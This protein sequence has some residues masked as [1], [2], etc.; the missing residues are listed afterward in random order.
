MTEITSRV[1]RLVVILLQQ[2]VPN[3]D[4]RDKRHK[5]VVEGCV[6][7][8]EQ[9]VADIVD[10]VERG[11]VP[12]PHIDVLWPKMHLILHQDHFF[13]QLV[14]FDLKLCVVRSGGLPGED[15]QISLIRKQGV[16]AIIVA[17]RVE[18]V[19]EVCDDEHD[20]EVGDDVKLG[21]PV[22]QNDVNVANLNDHTDGQLKEAGKEGE[23]E[24]A[25][26]PRVI[27]RVLHHVQALLE[28]LLNKN[29]HHNLRDKASHAVLRRKLLLVD[30]L[31]VDVGA[32]D[33]VEVE[34]E[35]EGPDDEHV[36]EV[37]LRYHIVLHPD[38]LHS[39][40]VQLPYVHCTTRGTILHTELLSHHHHLL[41]M[42]CVFLLFIK[43]FSD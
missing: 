42:V 18:V 4:G 30:A 36:F 23:A 41:H 5:V 14:F 19:V 3:E 31:K 12:E 33:D 15:A 38:M 32:E 8:L 40:L 43:V 24:V 35:L 37:V 39:I 26:L 10:L 28:F 11:A 2:H 34:A 20:D 9:F 1:F 25:E 22:G 7:E 13:T 21:L 29:V 27:H 16:N 17:H 6:E